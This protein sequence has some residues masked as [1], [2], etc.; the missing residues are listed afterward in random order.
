MHFNEVVGQSRIKSILI[1]GV[2]NDRVSHAQLFHDTNNYGALPLILSYVQF[3]FCE[4]KREQDSCGK[5]ASCKKVSKLAHPD[6]HF[7]F[8]VQLSSST[9][10][11]D[12]ILEEW[13]QILT[14]E[15]YFN[16]QDWYKKLG[17][18]NKTGVIGKDES[19][20]ILKK[21]QLKSFE[22]N[23]KIVVIYAIERM[24][25]AA[26]NKLL[27]LIEE[28]PARTLFLM[29]ASSLDN[30]LP[31]ILSRSQLIKLDKPSNDEVTKY[32]TNKGIADT[33]ASDIANFVNGNVVE[34]IKMMQEENSEEEFFSLFIEWMRICFSRDVGKAIDFSNTLAALGKEKQK[35][36]INYCLT[37]FQKSLT[38]NFLSLDKV[39]IRES[40]K[41]FMKKFTPYIN[42]SNIQKLYT[43]FTEAH[44]HIDRNANTKILFLDLSF[45][46][47]GQIK[48]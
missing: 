24:N 30:I 35:A 19:Q 48:K 17:N 26:A 37:I 2:K 23:Y 39:R 6:L 29:T 15:I 13:K 44:T 28:P 12:N 14:S 41:D 46:M 42:T 33:M 18:E 20:N 45:K 9:K 10:I 22:G 47:F 32:I 3:I 4:D 31:T 16:E 5:C 21:L 1:E 8:P 11:S 25:I 43:F 38:G 34:A 40:Q 7:S 27:K 36:F